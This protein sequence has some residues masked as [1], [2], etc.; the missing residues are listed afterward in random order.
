M[1]PPAP[2]LRRDRFTVTL[3]GSFIVWGWLLYSFNPSVPLLADDL[4]ISSAQAGLHGTA[5]ALG[6]IAAAFVAPWLVRT[7][8]RR[9]AL[10]S[11]CL[12]VAAGIVA[13]LA[14]PDLA[15]SLTAMLFLSLGG[16]V[17]IASAQPGLVMHHGAAASAAV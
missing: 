8:G 6:G 2:R 7:R 5:M 9:S 1:P 11:S 15:W 16:N 4:G 17:A 3:Y 14:A 10:V 13:I 12:L